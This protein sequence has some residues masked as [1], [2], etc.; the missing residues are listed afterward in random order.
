MTKS[1]KIKKY[2]LILNE[3]QV[4]VLQAALEFYFRI[5][6]RQFSRLDM[7]YGINFDEAMEIEE[8][9]EEKLGK[10][11]SIGSRSLD[12]TFKSAC[13]IHDVIRQKLAFERTPNGGFGLYFDDPFKWSKQPLPKFEVGYKK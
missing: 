3:D 4:N 8:F 12:D 2:K 1:N 9:L 5:G 11:L 7:L 13:D 10:P 6:M